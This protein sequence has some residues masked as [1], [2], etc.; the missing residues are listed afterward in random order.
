MA[1]QDAELQLKVSL[2]LA[3]FRQQL[4][5]L[6]Q[7]AAGTPLKLQVQFDRRSVQN[8]LNALGANIRRRNY[9]LNIET[10]L[11]AEIAKAD[12]LARKLTELSGKIK[13]A[14]VSGA[15]SGRRAIAD[16]EEVLRGGLTGK[17]FGIQQAQ[18]NIARQA[19]LSRLEK[20]SLSAGGYNVKGLEKIIRDLGGTPKGKRD[21]LVAQAKKLVEEADGISDAVFNNLKDLQMKLRPLRGQAQTSA[22]RSM[23]NLNEMLDRMANLTS[24]P[25]AAQRM[26]RMLPE[27]RITT[28]LVGAANRQA[29]FQEQFPQGFTLPG[30]NAPRAFDPLLKAIA[31]DFTDYAKSVNIS[32]PWVGQIGNGIAGIV[33]KAASTPQVQKL[34]PAAGQTTATRFNPNITRPIFAATQTV[35]PPAAQRFSFANGMGSL[36]QFPIAGMMGPSTPLSINARTSMFG[37]GGGM[38]PPGG[39]GGFRGAM[40][41]GPDPSRIDLSV[42]QQARVP[43]TGAIAELT[44]EF[45]NAAK[46]V[47]LFGTA[48]KALAFFTNLP[49][50]AFEAAKA[51]G[52]Y[53][54]QLQAVTSE[55]NTF[56]QSFAFVDNLA[57]RFNVP[58]ESAR[59]GFVK[60]YASMEP[61]GFSQGQIENLFE[62]VSKATAAFGLS[63]DKVDRVNYAFAQMASKGQIMSEELKGQ[64]GDVL[65]GALALFA[66]A[67]QMS[68]PEFSKAM[69]DGA[70]KGAAMAQVLDNVAILM[71]SKFGPAAQNASKTLQ[72]ALNQIQNNLKMMYESLTPFVNQFAAVFGPQV[73]SLIEDV[74]DA[75]KILTGS[76]VNGSDA[77]STLSPR[78]EAIY[79]VFQQIG[80]SAVSAA[81][82]IGS[83]ASSLQVFI[84]PLLSATKGVLDFISL[85]V[86]ARIGLY[87]TIIASLNGAF[88]LLARTGILQAT[89]AMVKFLATLNIA[90]LRVYI[91]GLQTLVAVLRSMITAANIA[92]VA[93]VGL[94]VALGGIIVTAIF[95]GLDLLAQR[96]LN[97]GSS[98]DKSTQKVRELMQELDRIAGSADVEAGT[99]AYLEANTKLAAARRANEKALADLA[100]AKETAP[101]APSAAA[102]V[103]AAQARADQAYADVL[104]ARREVNAARQARDIAVR[105]QEEERKRTQ[106]QLKPIDLSTGDG[107]GKKGKKGARTPL[108]QILDLESQ[109]QLKMAQSDR[110]LRLAELI[111]DAKL[112]G[113]DA[114]AESLE[115]LSRALEIRGKIAAAQQ[116]TQMLIDKEG[117]IIGKSLTQEEY[118]QKLQDTNVELYELQNDLQREFLKLQVSEADQAAK[119]VDD[120]AKKIAQQRDLN[121]L[122][123]DAAIASGAISP[124][125]AGIIEQ[126]R[127]FEDQLSRAKE[128]GATREQIV[129]LEQLQASM[130]EAGSLEEKIKALRDQFEQL[131]NWEYQAAEGAMAVGQALGEAMTTGVAGMISGTATAKEVFADFLKSV[132]QALMQAASQM[133]A[134]YIAIGIARIFAGLGGGGK[135]PLKG[136]GGD[137]WV[138]Y[139]RTYANGGIAPGGFKA[140][141][142]GGVVSGPT[143]GLVGEGKYNEAIVPLP[144]G[145]SIP[146]Q[147]RG[148]SSSRDLLSSNNSSSA[149][150]SPVLN[151]SFETT[152]INGV[153]YVSRDQLEQAMMET[154]RLAARDGATRGASLA[155]DKLQ[156]SPNTR[157]RIGIG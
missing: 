74:T 45:A 140:F 36:G 157:R 84:T 59:Q 70:L 11:S 25:R 13:P 133:I 76:F 39:S 24:N 119:A 68:I 121:R 112:A 29:A 40:G 53:K 95:T 27:S 99:R 94:K 107:D 49:N 10:N 62:G 5:G 90:Q 105:R 110:E 152:N 100:K 34:L 37:G 137:D 14:A 145:K 33:A 150:S 124:R 28:D 78:A 98:A 46:Q 103:E 80:P 50:Q 156:N 132:G 125:Q 47:L 32:D 18:E 128:L 77:L 120:L 139:T 88:Q 154:R 81:Q 89:V 115:S 109:R 86:V 123:E 91:A 56:E 41:F 149:G 2:D 142:N 113:N 21:D 82:N 43:L 61:A 12:T 71:N 6:G 48:Y 87:A 118:N 19:I 136:V 67:A 31:K 101:D 73:N 44:S 64:L 20:K 15:S 129:S 58:L 134:T 54:N 7:A 135:D 83:F 148:Q 146:V 102:R 122:L 138:K 26:L 22:A 57:Q 52:T 96:L 23:P 3:F 16:I 143:L 104:Q 85:P 126:R 72:G 35:Q 144:D 60:L 79:K 127:G 4:A 92:T 151:M 117:E 1:A 114:E 65:P 42:F 141:A 116:F 75:I 106:Q 93:V 66:E 130:P 155:I 38:Q 97:I 51:L 55:S 153:E 30:F 9:R 8:E 63:A 108:D 131:A 111:R 69:E 147:M 17:A